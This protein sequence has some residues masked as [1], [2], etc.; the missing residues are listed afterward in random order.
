MNKQKIGKTIFSKVLEMPLRKYLI[1]IQK[2]TRGLIKSFS[3]HE[4]SHKKI[5][6]A[7]VMVRNNNLCFEVSDNRLENI[8][9]TQNYTEDKIICSLNWINTRNRF[10]L[11]IL[12]SLLDYQSEYWFSGKDTDLKSL[13]LKEF[14]SLYPLPHFD[15]SR[16]SRLIS[17]LSVINPQNQ[18]INL[19]CLFISTR[20]YHAYLIKE[21]VEVNENALKDKDIQYL[22]TQKGINLSLRTICNCRKLLNIPNY[23]E[24]TAYN[25]EKYIY[26]CNYIMLS[27]KYLNKIPTEAGIYELSIQITTGIDYWNHR[28]SVIYIGSAKNLRK[29]LTNYL[30]NSLKNSLLSRFINNYN[31]FV[32]FY[33]TE[34]YILVEKNLLK[35]FKKNYGELPKANF[36]GG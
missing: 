19:K 33:L 22:L 5:F 35:N 24:K 36:L 25:Y 2:S 10:S 21:I 9:P 7:K 31:V 14:L 32:R 29:R 34:N 11:H 18:L 4:F 27:K 3:T 17:N 30:G 6:Y 26:F 20:K 13:T 23:K 28:S 12:K 8:Y 1:Y 16:L 15:Q